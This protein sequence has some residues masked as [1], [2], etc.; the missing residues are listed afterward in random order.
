M[1]SFNSPFS[2]LSDWLTAGFLVFPGVSLSLSLSCSCAGLVDVS[3]MVLFDSPVMWIIFCLSITEKASL[4]HLRCLLSL[5]LPPAVTVSQFGLYLCAVFI[6]FLCSS[7]S[8]FVVSL[9]VFLFVSELCLITPFH[10]DVSICPLHFLCLSLL[11]LSLSSLSLSL[12]LSLL[13]WPSLWFS[14]VLST[15]SVV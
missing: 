10:S 3:L 15:S 9:S 5:F 13:F 7:C 6:A 2:L 11:S 12:S 8:C 1:L 14:L 4:F